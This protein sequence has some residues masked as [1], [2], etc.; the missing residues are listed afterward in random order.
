MHASFADFQN[1]MLEFN[2]DFKEN[3]MKYVQLVKIHDTEA[4]NKK[5]EELKL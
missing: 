3:V 4:L 1:K 2:N 5:V